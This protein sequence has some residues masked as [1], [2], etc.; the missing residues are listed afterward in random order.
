MKLNAKKILKIVSKK[1]NRT[2]SNF[3]RK[4]DFYMNKKNKLKSKS[5]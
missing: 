1:N 5:F 3:V 4:K 2:V